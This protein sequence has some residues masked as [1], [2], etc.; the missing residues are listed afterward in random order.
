MSGGLYACAKAELRSKA[1]WVDTLTATC[2]Y[3]PMMAVGEMTV[4]GGLNWKECV[5]S[6]TVGFGIGAVVS[7]PMA[8]IRDWWGERV[9]KAD[10]QKYGVRNFAADLTFA[11]IAI[12]AV[13]SSV[14]AVSSIFSGADFET[15]GNTVVGGIPLQFKLMLPYLITLTSVRKRFGT[16]PKPRGVEENDCLEK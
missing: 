9:W 1:Y 6:R 12:P 8:R 2:F 16:T 5:W 15:L 3:T 13:Y 4:E 11:G 7:R 14:L 10:P